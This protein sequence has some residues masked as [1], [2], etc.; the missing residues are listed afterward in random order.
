MAS[1][2]ESVLVVAGGDLRGRVAAV[3]DAAG[4]HVR[5][6]ADGCTASGTLARWHPGAILFDVA[7]SPPD[8]RA[9]AEAYAR[10]DLADIALVALGAP[11]AGARVPPGLAPA[12]VVADPL[13]GPDLLATVW[14][15]TNP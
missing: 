2:R 15:V 4:Y 1:P 8:L 13:D 11:G 5:A 7:L 3:L 6:V 12:L 10:D 14:V 9:L